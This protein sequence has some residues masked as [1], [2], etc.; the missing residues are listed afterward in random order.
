MQNRMNATTTI[1]TLS[2]SCQRGVP[3][4]ELRAKAIAAKTKTFLIHSF[5]RMVRSSSRIIAA[6]RVRA[7]SISNERAIPVCFSVLLGIFD[8]SLASGGGLEG[9]KAPP[10]LPSGIVMCSAFYLRHGAASITSAED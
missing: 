10:D 4:I 5:G 1:R 8:F 9:L 7:G 6:P 3:V 2:R